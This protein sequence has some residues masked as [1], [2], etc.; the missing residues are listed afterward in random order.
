M[1]C[2][3]HLSQDLLF[4][5]CFDGPFLQCC[6]PVV[7]L[8]LLQLLGLFLIKHVSGISGN[9]WVCF[10]FFF[11]LDTRALNNVCTYCLQRVQC[12]RRALVVLTVE[13]SCSKS[14]KPEEHLQFSIQSF[15]RWCGELR[16]VEKQT[17][18][19]VLPCFM[20]PRLATKCVYFYA[21]AAELLVSKQKTCY[22]W[23]KE[24]IWLSLYFTWTFSTWIVG[25]TSVNLIMEI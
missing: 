13:L 6:F 2:K 24:I 17:C 21:V 16:C 4:P 5:C 8:Q 10:F 19:A 25:K 11:P 20:Q 9:W 1:T 23:Q 14:V 18:H 7:M 22:G 3:V 15:R 12:A